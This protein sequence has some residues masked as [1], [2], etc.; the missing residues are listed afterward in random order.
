MDRSRICNS[1]PDATAM[2]EMEVDENEWYEYDAE[3]MRR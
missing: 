1:V 2:C 3:P